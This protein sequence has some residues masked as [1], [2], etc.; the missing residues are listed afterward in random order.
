MVRIGEHAVVLGASMA[1]LLAARVLSEFYDR[2]TLVERDQLTDDVVARRGVPQSRQ[3]HALLAR[4][5]EIV[6]ELLPGFLEDMVAAGAHRWDDGD[7][8]RFDAVFGGHP[9]IRTGVIPNPDSLVNYYASRPFIEC[10]VRRRV[11]ALPNLTVLD[12]HDLV[13]LIHTGDRVTGVVLHRHAD[14]SVPNLH[15]Q[16]VV[17]A[18]GRGSRTPVFFDRLGY[19]RPPEQ[20][21]AVRV[22]YA[23][24]PVRIPDGTLHE[25]VI[26]RLFEP[27][28]PRG[29]VMFACENDTW[30]VGG[31]TLGGVEPPA[32][33]AELLDFGRGLIPD[34]A[35]AAAMAAEPL[36]DVSIHRFPANR[37]RRYDSMSR[38]PEGF[39]VMGDAV[40]SFNPIY[41]Q[42]MTIASIEALILRDCL[43]R[44]DAGLPRR[45]HRATAKKVRVAW[46]TAVGSDLALPEVAGERSLWMRASNVLVDRVL[47]AAEVNPYVAQEFLRV[48]GMVAEPT[49]MLRPSFVFHVAKSGRRRHAAQ[50]SMAMSSLTSSA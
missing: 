36:A 13:D 21:L 5:G 25:H 39:V 32:S 47:T 22:S 26:A 16:L 28:R 44:G 41:G 49:R 20:E 15:A 46:Q 42:G 29:F 40:C 48:T 45:F 33:R 50:G 8:T 10:H 27:G 7:L 23:S 17:D 19:G 12:E 30:V 31:G 35:M 18:T 37:W 2:V 4:C 14:G 38:T 3:P 11:L 6:E 43:R 24:M 1:G 34:H 9:I